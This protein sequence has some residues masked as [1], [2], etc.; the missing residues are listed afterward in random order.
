MQRRSSQTRNSKNQ[1]HHGV[2]LCVYGVFILTTWRCIIN[3]WKYDPSHRVHIFLNSGVCDWSANDWSS[4]LHDI[5]VLT[6]LASGD[7]SWKKSKRE[8][9][10][11]RVDLLQNNG[12]KDVK[13]DTASFPNDVSRVRQIS[14]IM[15]QHV[16]LRGSSMILLDSMCVMIPRRTDYGHHRWILPIS[17][18]RL[19]S[20]VLHFVHVSLLS[21]RAFLF[22][23]FRHILFFNII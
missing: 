17:E 15:W 3:D 23:I 7:E 5:W 11:D 13:C 14:L 18:S 6:T 21:I 19:L 8:F 20:R 2:F 4:F 16:L 22:S 9:L 1:S 12:K 10:H